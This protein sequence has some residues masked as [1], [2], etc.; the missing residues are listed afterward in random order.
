MEEFVEPSAMKR[1]IEVGGISWRKGEDTM[2]VWF[3][4]G[5]SW[6][7]IKD[8]KLRSERDG[9]IADV[10]IEGSDQHRGWFQSSLLTA[11]SSSEEERPRAPYGCVITHGMVLDENGRKMSKSLGNVISPAIVIH[12]GKVRLNLSL[13]LAN[14][15][16]RFDFRRIYKKNQL[17]ERMCCD[18]GSRRLNH[19]ETFRSVQ[20]Y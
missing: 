15:L 17:T 11:I 20:E 3:D 13:L 5:V 7:T 16:T 18:C 4:S 6:R 9:P 10:Y 19:R 8:L 12:G 14:K 1:S 2:D